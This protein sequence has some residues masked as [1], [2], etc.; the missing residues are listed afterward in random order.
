MNTTPNGK[1]M[2]KKD[3]YTKLNRIEGGVEEESEG[4]KKNIMIQWRAK[5]MRSWNNKG[6]R[7]H[8][9]RGQNN[10]KY[11]KEKK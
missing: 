8:K 11:A 4:V 5:S 3:Q 9:N 10:K 1:K 6:K 7:M 2:L